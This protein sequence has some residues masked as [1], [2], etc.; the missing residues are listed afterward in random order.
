MAAAKRKT[1]PKSVR[2]QVYDSMK[3]RCGYCGCNITY[4]EMQV[5]H[6]EAVYLHEEELNAGEAQQINS[7]ENY[8]P[9]CRACNFYKS[10]MS[11]EK[12][13]KQL[14]TPQ[15]RLEKIFIY[16]LAKKYGI[17]KEVKKPVQFYFE[18]VK[19]GGGSG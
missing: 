16:R 19:N 8:M 10:T 15:E 6:I 9:A 13:R 12:F 17:V 7:I 11:V 14:E 4:K 1:I 5:D 2:Q 3:G 18:K